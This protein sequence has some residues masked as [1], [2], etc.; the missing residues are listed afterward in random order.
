MSANGQA[1]LLLALTPLAERAVEELLFGDEQ[2]VAV[3]ASAADCGELLALAGRRD[4]DAVLLSPNL[5]GLCEADCVRLRAEGLHLLGLALDDRSA[6]ALERLAVDRILMPPLTAAEFA[7]AC[8]DAAPT[9]AALAAASSRA[10]EPGVGRQGSVVAVV[11]SAGSP[12]ASE[13]AASLA[14]LA[15]KSWR[16]LLVELDLLEGSLDLRLGCDPQRGSLLGLL[17]ASDADGALGELLERWTCGHEQGWPAVLLAP[18]QVDAHLDEL[19]RPGAI[20]A[21]L[22]AAASIYPLVVSDVGSMLELPGQL[23]AI[24]RCHREALLSADAVLLVLGAREDQLRAGRAQLTLLLET[25]AIGRER[26]RLCL[27]GAGAP[28]AAR[29]A[30]LEPFL[31]SELGELRLG[32]DAWLPYDGRAL[33]R[34]QR[35]GQ[36]LALARP[37]GAYAHAI[38]RL[39]SEL[40]LPA[41]PLPRE[42]KERLPVPAPEPQPE[43]E[44]VTLPWRS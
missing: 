37:R 6:D 19:T 13:C 11:G 31:A 23:P 5:S 24:A 12:G 18:P 29:R 36:P 41:Q 3:V 26:V 38:R 7:Q 15:A 40:L 20:R 43:P 42:R 25:L 14:A 2:P 8:G 44:E 32:I 10:H 28:G 33:A 27:N 16:T 21:A 35:A 1:R 34:A 30:E 4:A 39:L 17:R 9:V 22:D